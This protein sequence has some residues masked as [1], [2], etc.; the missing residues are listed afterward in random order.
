MILLYEKFPDQASVFNPRLY[1]KVSESAGVTHFPS[2]DTN[3]PIPIQ[4]RNDP[5]M[6]WD[7]G[8]AFTVPPQSV[9]RV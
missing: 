5:Q 8:R 4:R 1:L 2:P 7:K 9:V 3:R 6:K